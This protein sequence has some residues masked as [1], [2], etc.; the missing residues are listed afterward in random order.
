MKAHPEW[1]MLYGEGDEF[2]SATGLQQRY[3]SLPPSVGIEG[4]ISHCF[5]CQPTVLFRR[6]MGL[7]LG[8]FDEKWR[9]SFDLIIGCEHSTFPTARLH[10][11]LQG[12]TRLHGTMRTRS[13]AEWPWSPELIEHFGSAPITRLHNLGL[14]QL[15]LADT[16]P[17]QTREL[18]GE[19]ADQAAPWLDPKVLE[20]SP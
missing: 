5:I 12:R 19:L 15:G 8:P 16:K 18:L 2:N 4:F 7:L 10:P 1:L 3:P 6:S 9:T 14:E 13:E 20:L 17:G 11:Y